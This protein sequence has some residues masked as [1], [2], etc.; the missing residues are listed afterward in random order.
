MHPGVGL[1][2][3]IVLN[4]LAGDANDMGAHLGSAAGHS[5]H[6]ANV[7][8]GYHRMTGL[9]QQT[10][11]MQG[12]QISGVTGARISAAKDANVHNRAILPQNPTRARN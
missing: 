9:A 1:A 4:L 5:F 8:T 12:F 2:R 6:S 11:K 3:A 7:S 10:A